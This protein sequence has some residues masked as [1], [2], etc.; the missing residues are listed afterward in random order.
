MGTRRHRRHGGM[1]KEEEDKFLAQKKRERSE[2]L[3]SV[4][5]N[6]RK[7]PLVVEGVGTATKQPHRSLFQERQTEVAKAEHEGKP[8]PKAGRRRRSHKRKHTRRRR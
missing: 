5:D 2:S 8:P 6:S 1:T 4:G 7:P 3:G